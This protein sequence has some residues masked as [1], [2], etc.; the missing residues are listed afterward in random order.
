[1]V[2]VLGMGLVA[3][4]LAAAISLLPESTLAWGLV[5]GPGII[6]LGGLA[7]SASPDAVLK[8]RRLA[9][10]LRWWHWL[11][12]LVFLSGLVFRVRDIDTIQKAPL[13]AWAAWRVGLMGVV[14]VVLLSRLPGR[15]TDWVPALVRG[16]LSGVF[17]CAFTSV[18]STL[19]SV[20]PL[21]TL[22]RSIEYLID[23]ALLAAIVTAVRSTEELKSLFDWTWVLCGLLLCTVWL[24]VVLRPDIAVIKG[25][26]L[27][28]V[29]VQ[30]VLPAASANAV[31]DMGAILLIIAGTRLLFRKQSRTFYWLV[32]L[33]AIPT[34]LLSQSR[35]PATGAMLGL[36][37]VLLV[38]R[39]FG[40]LTVLGIVTAAFMTLTSAEAVVQQA[41]LRG[42]NPSLFYSLSGRVGWWTV[43]WEVLREHPVLGLGGYAGARFAVLNSLGVT[44]ASSIHNAWLDILLGVG[45]V[46]F[47]PLLATLGGVWVNLLR[48]LYGAAIPS[49]VREVRAEALAIFVLVWVRSFFTVE[50]TWHPSLLFLLV[51]AQAEL[52]RRS[53]LPHAHPARWLRIREHAPLQVLPAASGLSAE[54]PLRR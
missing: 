8:V 12:F 13:D 25:I 28:G 53:R 38:E 5:G 23:L 18:V 36:L 46:G 14:A 15:R 32:C 48:P 33:V 54:A 34:L 44:D 29:Q 2:I 11:W 3:V 22:Y 1:M 39:R 27:I 6:L 51:L 16:L 42:Q 9:G 4:G 17:L 43:A 50:F 40:L 10:E 37:A 41:F 45:I 21:W 31:G 30:G 7:I 35:S 26:G 19:W 24:G 49:T 52:L 20:Y 47:V